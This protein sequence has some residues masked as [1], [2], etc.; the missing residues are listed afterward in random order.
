MTILQEIIQA[1]QRIRPYI[2]E[3][4]L[5]YS[6][7]LSQMTGCRVFLKLEN[8]QHT[9]SFKVRGA[10]NALLALNQ[11][12]QM[13]GVV[14]ASSGNHG[15]AI[16]FGLDRL[17]LKGR[18]FVPENVSSAKVAAIK[19]FGGEVH[20]YG[21]DSAFTEEFARTYADQNEMVYISPYN[22]VRVIGGQGTI[23]VEMSRQLDRVDV[24][25]AAVGGGGLISGIASYL[26]AVF[27]EVTV[28]GCS[29]E[30]SPAMQQSIQQG[31]IV[32]LDSLPTLSDGTA[33]GLESE[34]IT[35]PL[36]Q[37][38]VADYILVSEEEIRQAL[39]LFIETHHMLIEGAAA[40][41]LAALL[42]NA[43]QFQGKTVAVVLCGANIGLQ[44]LKEVL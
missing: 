18:I 30:H 17:H 25:L 9:G 7:F 27:G 8:L 3:T 21:E 33:G 20:Y 22:D 4:P 44:T 19:S 34:A 28:I 10:M 37:Q 6:P 29:P 15:I 1:E 31:H 41:A 12:Q 35:F 24:V 36:C 23:G 26:K 2:R 16:A 14:T 43:N 40:V 42:K 32:T 5:D 39:R 11:K 13:R 38:L